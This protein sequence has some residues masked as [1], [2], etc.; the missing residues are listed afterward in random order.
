VAVERSD[1][2]VLDA[3]RMGVEQE[4][5]HGDAVRRRTA[6]QQQH[7]YA[8][9]KELLGEKAVLDGVG[10]GEANL[11]GGAVGLRF[12]SS[13]LR[14]AALRRWALAARRAAMFCAM[15]LSDGSW[16]LDYIWCVVWASKSRFMNSGITRHRWD[17]R[18]G[19]TGPSADWSCRAIPT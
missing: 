10:H 18:F 19:R 1:E 16:A 6:R 8:G 15:G 17:W 4:H 11:P 5:G 3:H 12:R 9:A 7:A 14:H 2:N 13:L